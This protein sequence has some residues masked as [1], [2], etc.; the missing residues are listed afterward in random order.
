MVAII[1]IPL[2][3]LANIDTVI[4]WALPANKTNEINNTPK[5]EMPVPEAN[6]PKANPI[7]I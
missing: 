6:I 5:G 3:K 7:G 4:N 2:D 1:D